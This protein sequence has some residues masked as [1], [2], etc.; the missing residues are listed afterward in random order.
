MFAELLYRTRTVFSGVYLT[1]S[2]SMFLKREFT[3]LKV[4]ELIVVSHKWELQSQLRWLKEEARY[5][6]Y[7][8]VIFSASSSAI[9]MFFFQ[10]ILHNKKAI[11]R[12]ALQRTKSALQL[13][14]P[15]SKREARHGLL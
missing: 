13:H 2:N 12:I 11:K 3:I 5:A 10:T 9:V 8:N 4:T 15:R 7:V 1:D 6:V 14:I